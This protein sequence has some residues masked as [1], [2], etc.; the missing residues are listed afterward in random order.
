MGKQIACGSELIVCLSE[1]VTR[2]PPTGFISIRDLA[3]AGEETPVVARATVMARAIEVWR[4]IIPVLPL[5]VFAS[6]AAW[7][8]FMFL[9]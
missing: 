9:E 6:N 4:F 5:S 2:A 3:D 8:V 7:L 1:E